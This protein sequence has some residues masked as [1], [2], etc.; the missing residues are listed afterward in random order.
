MK[1]VPSKPVQDSPH[2]LIITISL[3]HI[4]RVDSAMECH[5]LIF[6]RMRTDGCT[7]GAVIG[8]AEKV[9]SLH[10]I[11]CKAKGH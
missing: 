1:I 4:L 5:L 8:W 9:Q 10:S 7:I 3:S 2:V 6:V 11:K